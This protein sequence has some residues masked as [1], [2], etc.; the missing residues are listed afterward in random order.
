MLP[1]LLAALHATGPGAAA[2]AS[3]PDMAAMA[4]FA[5]PGDVRTIAGTGSPGLRDGSVSQA[6][7]VLPVAVAFDGPN[8]IVIVDQGAQRIRE[9]DGGGVRTLAGSGDLKMGDVQVDGGYRDGS[10]GTAQFNEPSG[11][12]VADDGGIYIAD[13]MNHCIRLLRSGTVSTFAGSP[14]RAGNVNGSLGSAQFMFPRALAFD[15]DGN[16]FVA[17]YRSGIREI[18]RKGNV[19]TLS[20]PNSGENRFIAVAVTGAG[21]ARTLMASDDDGRFYTWR[22]GRDGAEDH[23]DVEGRFFPHFYGLTAVNNLVFLAT[24]I[25]TNVIRL[26]RLHDPPFAGDIAAEAVAGTAFENGYGGAGYRD[27]QAARALFY[28]PMGIATGNARVV[29]ADAGNRRIR[30]MPLPDTRTPLGTD[31][32]QLSPD[33]SHYRVLYVGASYA[34]YATT[35]SGSVPGLVESE[36]AQ[37]RRHIGLPLAPRFSAARLDSSGLTEQANFVGGVA[38]DGQVNLVIFA[39]T[40]SAIESVAPGGL[41]G[42]RHAASLL[43]DLAA[44]LAASN[45]RLFVFLRPEVFNASLV[46]EMYDREKD[47]PVPRFELN[48][49][50]RYDRAIVKAFAE[51][52][53]PLYFAEDDY[54]GYESSSSRLPLWPYN[55]AHYD[56]LGREFEAAILVRELERLRPWMSK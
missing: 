54:L 47:P 2:Q 56:Q 39:I 32:S 18:D 40:P 46:D 8:R 23:L 48:Y 30:E 55:D 26:V 12:A 45:T 33:P 50:V 22:P 13:Q 28:A 31:L 43:R 20:L 38:A 10:A 21:N 52:A 37:D 49:Y 34:F 29:I 41:P 42:L 11:I 15:G 5:E 3:S 36:L 1:L 25:R 14:S 9:L 4:R 51:T 27:G 16:L 53:V 24:D 17:D 6:E 44:R 35:W 19:T 7:F